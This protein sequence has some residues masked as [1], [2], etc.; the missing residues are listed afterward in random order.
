MER[1]VGEG[2][3]GGLEGWRVGG[4]R[5]GWRVGAEGWRGGLERVGGLEVRYRDAVSCGVDFCD[6]VVCGGGY[7]YGSVGRYRFHVDRYVLL[8]RPCMSL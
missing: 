4:G 3:V 5:V 2:R 1:R 6:A 7:R 8:Q